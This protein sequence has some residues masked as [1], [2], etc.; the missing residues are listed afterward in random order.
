VAVIAISPSMV[1]A[2][3]VTLQL[4]ER[5]SRSASVEGMLVQGMVIA[6]VE[7]PAN[8]AVMDSS[9]FCLKFHVAA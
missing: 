8:D 6:V 2:E 9:A 5:R 3:E 4:Q 7:S 1:T